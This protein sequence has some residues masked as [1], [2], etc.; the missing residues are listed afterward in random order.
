[1]GWWEW[2]KRPNERIRKGNRMGSGKLK[3]FSLWE[4]GKGGTSRDA[5]RFKLFLA[6][7]GKEGLGAGRY[8]PSSRTPQILELKHSAPNTKRAFYCRNPQFGASF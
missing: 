4:F 3:D 1:M 7:V 2:E 8:L 6:A 5:L